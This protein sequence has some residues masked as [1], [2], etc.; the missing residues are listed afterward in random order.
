MATFRGATRTSATVTAN[1]QTYASSGRGFIAALQRVLGVTA[2]G[3][4]GPGT[5]AALLRA[6]SSSESGVTPDYVQAV[7]TNQ[8]ERFIGLASLQ[9]AVYFLSGGTADRLPDSTTLPQW[10]V[11]PGGNASDPLTLDGVPQPQSGMSTGGGSSVPTPRVVPTRVPGG[12][13]LDMTTAR[14]P[15]TGPATTLGL[16]TTQWLIGLGV[17][18]GAVG[19]FVIASS[20]SGPSTPK[21]VPAS[22][23]RPPTM[24]GGSTGRRRSPATVSG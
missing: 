2:D 4:W 15:A 8:D 12:T 11:A 17:V 13:S 16:T 23:R 14:P 10:G 20:L 9:T 1:G 6:A 22:G 7:R 3:N 19:V 24:Y 21:R 5:Q 18:A